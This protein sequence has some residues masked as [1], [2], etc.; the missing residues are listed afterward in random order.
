MTTI[1]LEVPDEL[2]NQ[3]DL[4]RLPELLREFVTRKALS[5]NSPA[6]TTTELPLYREITDFLTCRPTR[7]QLIAFKI[8][9]T[10][11]ARLED[12]LAH[13]Q[14]APLAP[15]E[16]ADLD[17]YLQLSEWLSTLKARARSGQIVLE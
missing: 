1:M 5:K 8:S 10:A 11:Q 9:P 13:N 17:T 12:L 4:A 7:E 15:A 2:T 3:I 6:A 16:R 14:D